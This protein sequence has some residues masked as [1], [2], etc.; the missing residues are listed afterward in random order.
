[1]LIFNESLVTLN[2]AAED[3]TAVINELAG[4]LFDQGLVTADYGKQTCERE[5]LHPTGLPTKPFCIAFPHADAEGA[6]QSAL[7]LATLK[8]PVVFRNMGDPD[9]DLQVLLVLMLANRDPSE[10]VKTLRNLA[11]LFGKPDQLQTLRDQS[12]PQAVVAWLRRELRLD[13]AA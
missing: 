2:H 11:V 8:S 10:Q 7:A 5:L 9:E 3:S 6:H 13:E 1:M 12:T 4:K